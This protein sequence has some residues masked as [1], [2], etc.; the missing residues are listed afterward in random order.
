MVVSLGFLLLVSLLI[1]AIINAISDRL[2]HY[3]P[4]LSLLVLYVVNLLLVFVI[5]TLLFGIIFKVLP[6]AKIKWRHVLAGAIAT[7]F[8]FMIGKWA[9]SFYLGRSTVSSTYGAA[10]SLIVVLLWVYYSAMILYFG[11]EFTRNFSQWKGGRIYPNDYAVW[12][13]NVEVESKAK[14]QPMPDEIIPE[15]QKP[16]PE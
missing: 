5:T 1:N 3:M 12:I 7:A 14:L 8:L 4:Q 9:I 11:A 10:G 6:D 13:E 2:A 16:D 15:E